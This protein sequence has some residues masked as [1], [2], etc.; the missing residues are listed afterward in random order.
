MLVTALLILTILPE[1]TMS[2]LLHSALH[3]ASHSNIAALSPTGS[4]AESPPV[5]YSRP[6][7]P[8]SAA[9]PVQIGFVGLGAMGAVM[10]KNLSNHRASH[11]HGSPPI[12][13]WNRTQAKSDQ[14]F[15]ELGQH[16]IRVAKTV[17]QVATECDVIF[18]NLANDAVVRSIYQQFA[19][20]LKHAPPP[21]GKIFVETSTVCIVDVVACSSLTRFQI[22]PTLAGELDTLISSVPHCRLI[23]SPVF[24]TPHVAAAAQLVIVMSGDY[25]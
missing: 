7:T 15:T 18:T 20:T 6:T 23:T 21:R 25:R 24:G 10:A 19:E 12:L 13:V 22:Y 17:E 5:P 11:V 16:K 8:G 1:F 14:L 3:S 9:F 2:D 4:G